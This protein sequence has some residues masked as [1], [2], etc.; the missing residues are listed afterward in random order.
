MKFLALV[1][2]T[3]VEFIDPYDKEFLLSYYFIIITLY[4]FD[5]ICIFI[6]PRQIRR[7]KF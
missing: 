5:I 6:E 7:W 2:S 4:E 1:D 3:L